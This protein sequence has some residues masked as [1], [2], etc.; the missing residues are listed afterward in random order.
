MEQRVMFRYASLLE[1]PSYESKVLLLVHDK[2][3]SQHTAA[4]VAEIIGCRMNYCP[5]R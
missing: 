1:R 2:P 3:R 4:P 5:R